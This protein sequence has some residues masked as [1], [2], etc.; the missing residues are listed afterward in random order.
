MILEAIKSLLSSPL[1]WK[2]FTTQKVHFHWSS[3]M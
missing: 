2:I 3:I 1:Y